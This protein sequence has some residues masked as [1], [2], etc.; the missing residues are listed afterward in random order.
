MMK[1]KSQ[2]V[3]ISVSSGGVPKQ[4]VPSA[5][6]TELGII[7]DSQN[8]REHHGGPERA[9][10][11]YSLERIQALQEEGHPIYPGSTGENLTISGLE[12]QKLAPGV[13][14]QLG[15]VLAQI[16]RYASPC[17]NISGSF[18]N[19]DFN[20]I[21][22]KKNPGWS[23]FCLRVLEPGVIKKGDDVVWLK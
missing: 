4:E 13:H 23:R 19:G 1:N 6:V 3:Q 11:I 15:Q 5:I 9:L 12:W 17:S 8:D 18:I 22:Q 20:R 7:T 2:I 14:L 16:T 21:G 10:I